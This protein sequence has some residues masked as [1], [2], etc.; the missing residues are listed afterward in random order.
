MQYMSTGAKVGS[1]GSSLLSMILNA[2]GNSDVAQV[3]D[4]FKNGFDSLE[5]AVGKSHDHTSGANL[6]GQAVVSSPNPVPFGNGMYSG[7]PAS[8]SPS[9]CIQIG[10]CRDIRG[11][12]YPVGIASDMNLYVQ[13][14]AMSFM[15]PAVCLLPVHL[16]AMMMP[17]VVHPNLGQQPIFM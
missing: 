5:A 17:Y 11:A 7:P 1:F 4:V 9:R 3:F 2:T 13:C 12:I 8:S 16:N 14:Y 6:A 15:G 10:Y